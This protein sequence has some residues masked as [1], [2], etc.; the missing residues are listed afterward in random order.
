MIADLPELIINMTFPIGDRTA[1]LGRGAD[2]GHHHAAAWYL[3]MCGASEPLQRE[4]VMARG[5]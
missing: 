4:H 5:A 1:D 2:L 3:N